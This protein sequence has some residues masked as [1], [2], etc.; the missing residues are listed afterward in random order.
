MH[1]TKQDE[2]WR[3]LFE[4]AKDREIQIFASS[5]S[6]EMIESFLR[7]GKTREDVSA[8]YFEMYRSPRSGQIVAA[9]SNIEMLE[10]RLARQSNLRGEVA[11]K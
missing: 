7:I 5:H 3:A 8:T 11:V 4:I 2:I 10:Y 9:P 6:K 1:Y